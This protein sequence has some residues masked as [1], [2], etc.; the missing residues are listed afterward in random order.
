MVTRHCAPGLLRRARQEPI[1]RNFRG[2]FTVADLQA[3]RPGKRYMAFPASSEDLQRPLRLRSRLY[4]PLWERDAAAR[5]VSWLKPEVT[6][7]Q[8]DQICATFWLGTNQATGAPNGGYLRGCYPLV[9][10][11]L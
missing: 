9:D 2:P 1:S 8:I 11:A 7:R 5:M 6:T 3:D 4:A 10:H